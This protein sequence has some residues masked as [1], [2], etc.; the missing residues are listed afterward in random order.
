MTSN[1]LYRTPLTHD[2]AHREVERCAG[3]QFDPDIVHGFLAA[4]GALE[5]IGV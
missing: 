5:T 2:E 3:S 4:V 1:R